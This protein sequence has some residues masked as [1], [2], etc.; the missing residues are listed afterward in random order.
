ML[1]DLQLGAY[2]PC[3]ILY[4]LH[5]NGISLMFAFARDGRY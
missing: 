2:S 3:I 5:S 1:L 4:V